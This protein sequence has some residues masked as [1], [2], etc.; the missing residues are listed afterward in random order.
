M[1]DTSE[2]ELHAHY[3]LGKER[4]RYALWLA[5]LGYTMEHRDLV[6]LHVQQFR[7]EA[8][9][10]VCS[11]VGDARDLDLRPPTSSPRPAARNQSS[12]R[13]NHSSFYVFWKVR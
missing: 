2:A 9:G 7:A 11:A 13:R 6:P 12:C 3:A 8:N 1:T 5:D 4:D 10:R